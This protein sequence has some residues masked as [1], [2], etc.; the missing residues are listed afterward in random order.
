M[1]ACARSLRPSRLLALARSFG[2]LVRAYDV[3]KVA[4]IVSVASL[5]GK[6]N[7]KRRREAPYGG[8]HV[9]PELKRG[10][11]R[12]TSDNYRG[13]FYNSLYAAT[14]TRTAISENLRFEHTPCTLVLTITQYLHFICAASS[15]ADR[16]ESR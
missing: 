9:L 1:H 4:S 14:R 11:A 10:A 7:G 15:K 8:D 2:R 12:R 3:T 5:A 16:E 13:T 6:D